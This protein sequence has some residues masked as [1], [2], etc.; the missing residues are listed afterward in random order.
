[1]H[2]PSSMT[3][4]FP[5]LSYPSDPHS[6]VSS[7]Q[8]RDLPH[9]GHYHHNHPQEHRHPAAPPANATSAIFDT[10][11]SGK[12]RTL[13]LISSLAINL[14]LPFV[15]GVMLG[16]GE[17]FARNVAVKWFGWGERSARPAPPLGRVATN[18][19]V[20]ATTQGGGGKVPWRSS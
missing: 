3:S 16:F 14:F 1:M 5:S 15:N 7:Q 6:P 20:N 12:T 11:L 2:I 8:H 4:S 19:G 13:A 18:A 10:T 17:I 9:H